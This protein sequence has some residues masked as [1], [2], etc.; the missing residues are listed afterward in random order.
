MSSEEKKKLS[1]KC[2][3]FHG[4][5]TEEQQ[6]LLFLELQFYTSLFNIILVIRGKTEITQFTSQSLKTTSISFT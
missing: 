1:Q 2:T 6:E 3:R 5:A 4:I